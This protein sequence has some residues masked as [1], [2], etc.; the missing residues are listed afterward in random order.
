MLW[1]PEHVVVEV[2]KSCQSVRKVARVETVTNTMQHNT[3]DVHV[4]VQ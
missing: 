3:T 2:E 4:L 1:A